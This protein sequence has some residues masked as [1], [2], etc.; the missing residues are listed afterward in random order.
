MSFALE[1]LEKRQLLS[2]SYDLSETIIGPNGTDGD[3]FGSAVATQGSLAVITAALKTVDGVTGAGEAYLVDTTNGQ[4]LHTFTNPAP[5]TYDQ[6]GSCATFVGSKVAIGEAS[7]G[8]SSSPTVFVYDMNDLN[9]APLQISAPLQGSTGF[10][11]LASNGT[12]LFVGCIPNPGDG[13]GEVERFDVSTGALTQTYTAPAGDLQ[14][15]TE[16]AISG[17]TLYAY[18]YDNSNPSYPQ[19]SVVEFDVTSGQVLDTLYQPAAYNSPG[20]TFGS[21]LAVASN[22]D[23]F[24]GGASFYTTGGNVY[25]YSSDNTLIRTYTSPNYPNYGDETFGYRLATNDQ[26]QLLVGALTT[27]AFDDPNNPTM[28]QYAGAAYVFD[29]TDGSSVAM[30]QNPTPTFDLASGSDNPDQFSFGMAALPNGQFIITDNY[31]NNANGIDAGAAY[32]FAPHVEVTN[33]PPTAVIAPVSPVNEDTT[34]T[35]DASG[36]TDPNGQADIVSYSWDLNN[37]GT[38]GD[39][40]GA[41]VPFTEDLP[42]TYPVSVQVTD[43]A[44]NQSVATIDVT[45]NDVLPTATASG[46]TTGYPGQNLNFAGSGTTA[47]GDSI[48]SYE[49]DFNYDGNPADFAASASGTNVSHSFGAVGNYTVALRVTDDDGQSAISTLAVS[50]VN[51]PPTAGPITGPASGVRQQSLAFNGSFTDPDANDAHQVSWDFGDGNTIAL[52]ST[53]DTGALSPSHIYTADGT[54]TVTMTVEDSS[55]A[56]SSSQFVV[57]ITSSGMQGGNLYVGAAS[58]GD[59]V[60]ITHNSSGVVVHVDGGTQTYGLGSG[61]IYIYGGNG[62]DLLAVSNSISNSVL[63]DGGAGDDIIGG[64][65]G[66][67]ILLGGSGDDIIIGGAGRDLMIGGT[68]SD[69]LVGNSGDDI[70]IAGT[71]S[72]DNNPTALNAIMAEWASSRTYTQRVNN[73]IDGSGSATRANG[74]Y[75]IMPDVTA[76]DDGSTDLL[77]GGG[78]TDWYVA[79][80]TAPNADLLVGTN[81]TEITTAVDEVNV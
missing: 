13:I 9:A 60:I 62:N 36:S 25:Q 5:A 74:N 20:D 59:S 69:A 66:N 1:D 30:I 68:G 12:D 77:V 26:N 18:A 71:T 79:D 14:L 33:Q 70:L 55:G 34:V 51:T 15:G 23:F 61:M 3:Q 6:F 37:D 22:G 80:T 4:I 50:V 11:T 63:I 40:T 35:L 57:A 32:V 2:A 75:F 8:V 54:Y 47:S 67:D 48:V 78:G 19:G 16:M 73:L 10:H 58:G 76:F 45:F 46:D 21:A 53:D 31:D 24:V 38:F 65:S 41:T 42:G 17:N 81:P 52:H 39:A 72:Y 56:T 29:Y 28:L 43:S 44:G 64:G 27:I 7:N 49:W